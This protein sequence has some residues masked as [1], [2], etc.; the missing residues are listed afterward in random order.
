M[1]INKLNYKKQP[2]N[3]KLYFK[4]IENYCNLNSPEVQLTIELDIGRKQLKP[5]KSGSTANN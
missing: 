2:L 1:L 3:L 5:E 4:T